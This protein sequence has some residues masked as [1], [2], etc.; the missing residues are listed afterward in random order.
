MKGIGVVFNID[1]LGG[2]F[3]GAQAWRI[4]MRNIR[5]ETIVGAILR[6][7]D[8]NETLNGTAREFCIAAFGID[9]DVVKAALTHATEKGLVELHRR[10]ILSPK[11]DSEPL[12]DA[13]MIDSLG[14]LVQDEWSRSFHDRC[15]D[16]G[17]G[18][19][20]RKIT[21]DLSADLKAELK[22]LQ[23]KAISIKTRDAQP[24]STSTASQASKPWWKFWA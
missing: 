5:P 10:F 12:V 24:A 4:F 22:L 17:W 14:R 9:V 11:L 23:A 1:D 18:F 19:A 15:K 21:V 6:E 7:G 8:T 13:G 3:Y 20:P 2:G 16:C